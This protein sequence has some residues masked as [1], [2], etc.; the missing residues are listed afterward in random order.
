M[1]FL[2]LSIYH[3]C[4]PMCPLPFCIPFHLTN[5]TWSSFC[6]Q[7]FHA[8]LANSR[9][10]HGHSAGLEV[11]ARAEGHAGLGRIH[12]A[13]GQPSPHPGDPAGWICEDTRGEANKQDSDLVQGTT[14][15][16]CMFGHIHAF[17]EQIKSTEG[18][19][20][21]LLCQA[22]REYIFPSLLSY[23]STLD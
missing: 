18:A 3:L 19:G 14:F 15:A 17:W 8:A 1:S 20:W 7:T 2:H 13:G 12:R 9:T 11:T 16:C 5:T 22:Q 10:T 4:S 23:S 21:W 6:L